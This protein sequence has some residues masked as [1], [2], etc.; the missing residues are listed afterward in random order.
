MTTIGNPQLKPNCT[1]VIS[2]GEGVLLLRESGNRVLRGAIYEQLIPLLDGSH[3]ADQ[4]VQA[5]SQDFSPAEVYF[6]LISLQS[7]NYLC[8]ALH[9]LKPREAAFW[10]DLELDPEQA[11]SRVRA[12]RVA[13]KG[14]GQEHSGSSLHSMRQAI[15][16][17]GLVVVDEGC[18][19]DLTLVVCD[20]YLEPE[21]E[22]LN[23]SFRRQGRRWLL[24][25]PNG[26]ELWLGPLFE[27]EQPGCFACLSRLLKRHRQ[28]ERFA[29]AVAGIPQDPMVK[30]AHAPGAVVL[31][32]YWTSLEVG[33]ILAGATPQ[34]TNQV[35]TFN[36]VDYSSERHALVVDPHCPTCGLEPLPSFKPVVLDACPVRFDQDGGHRHVSAEET[37]ERF[38]ALIS[39]ISG[40]VSELLPVRSSL[41]S[42]QVVVAGH[43]PAQKLGSLNDLRRNLRSA[44]AGKGASMEQARASALG[45]ALERFSGEQHPGIL[46]ERGSLQS[47]RER[48]GDVVIAPNAVMLF[49]ELQFSE[50]DIWN[51][52]N[53]RF[54]NVPQVLDPECEI[55]WTPIW[56]ISKQRRCFLP[57]QLLYFGVGSRRLD[58]DGKADPWIAVGCSNG[59]AAGNTLEEAVLQGFL[60]LVE[61]DSVAIWW[62]N[63]L[64]RPG[65]DLSST[66]DAWITRLLHDYSSIGREVWALDLT[67][68]LGITT[69]VALSRNRE[70]NAEQILM[71]LGCHLDPRIA[72][73]R[74][75]AEMNQML[76]IANAQVDGVDSSLDDWETLEWLTKATLSNQPYLQPNLSIPLRSIGDLEDHHSGDLLQDIQHCCRCV[77]KQGME[78]LVLDQ[79]RELVGLPVVK[80]VVPGLRHFWA[81]YGPGRLYEVPMRM[82]QLQHSL[83]E[84]ELNPTPIFF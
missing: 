27:P 28:V 42:V 43:N 65:I 69:V 39:P 3:S 48:Y 50:R 54:N 60:E 32:A 72:V 25:K 40:I 8:Q 80:V 70:A 31:A 10:A 49:S 23:E 64:S 61:R 14:V 17:I 47:M 83:T 53:S 29:A 74:A 24:V 41:R 84:D 2:P 11:M 16:D 5:L 7:R 36:V 38:G 15:I 21:L 58:V 67:T 68:D 63:R 78:V 20:S 81:R 35:V 45:E 34:T 30:Q 4:L 37:L 82:G 19:A 9:S 56:S 59:S 33:R 75:L 12:S 18:E 57:T 13:L 55:D 62:Y 1:P 26:R 77:E 71:G 46:C 79:T 66:G 76:G 52:K 6:T 44:A 73:Q 51:S 22:D